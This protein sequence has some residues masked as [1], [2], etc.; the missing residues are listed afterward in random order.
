MTRTRSGKTLPELLVIVV[1][2]L[3]LAGMLAHAVQK[4]RAAAGYTQNQFEHSS[5][6]VAVCLN[7]AQLP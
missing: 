3:G 4:V 6:R 5:D 7:T 2:L 1:V